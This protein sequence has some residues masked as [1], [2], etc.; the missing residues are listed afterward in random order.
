MAVAM[1][2]GTVLGFM[3]T[4]G[5]LLMAIV[6]AIWLEARMPDQREQRVRPNQAGMGS[7]P[8]AGIR[9]EA[10]EHAA[11]TPPVRAT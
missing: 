11:V 9:G 6:G 2:T 8:W 3:A 10:Q 5:I 1:T 4:G 7:E